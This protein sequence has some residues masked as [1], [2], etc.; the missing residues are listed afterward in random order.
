MLNWNLEKALKH[1]VILIE[2]HEEA[3]R[4]EVLNSIC[5]SMGEDDFDRQHFQGDEAEPK[6]WIAA[7][8]VSPFLSERRLVIVRNLLRREPGSELKLAGLP[9]YALLVLVA[10]DE[11]GDDSKQKRLATVC[12]NWAKA[13]A[14]AKG[15]SA[16]C[17]VPTKEAVKSLKGA[18]SMRNRKISDRAAE[19]L[20]EMT[21][22]SYSRAMEEFDKIILFIGDN[23]EVRESDV[24]EIAM[25]SREWNVFSLVDSIM[26]GRTSQ[27]L[28]QVRTLVGGTSKPED[29]A[30]RSVLPIISRQLRLL[31]Q[32]RI[33]VEHK[34]SP[35]SAPENVRDLMPEKPNLARESEYRQASIM[36][37]ANKLTLDKLRT[38]LSAVEDADAR[39]K[40]ILPGF[41][42]NETLERLVLEMVEAVA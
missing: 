40:G 21:G 26:A 15:Y 39:L 8:G 27:A 41:S 13:V 20:L 23:P 35:A 34:V 28:T 38:C 31:W 5:Q 25:P 17:E 7:A 22:G 42:T 11:Q 12:K 2:G 9:E 3:L 30:F 19:T 14:S 6:E 10:D 18:A 16:N 29:A 33:C 4:R 36:R 24:L 1:Q 37:A 32:A